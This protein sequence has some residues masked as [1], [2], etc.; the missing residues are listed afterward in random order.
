MTGQTEK[1][2]YSWPRVLV[3]AVIGGLVFAIAGVLF[4]VVIRDTAPGEA[5]ATWGIGGLLF[6][7]AFAGVGLLISYRRR[8]R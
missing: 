4:Q 8:K 3:P 2:I 6:A 1:S 5:V 7:V